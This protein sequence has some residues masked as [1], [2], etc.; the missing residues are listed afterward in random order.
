MSKLE[1]VN[2][3][4]SLRGFLRAAI[5]DRTFVTKEKMQK[6]QGVAKLI[7]EKILEEVL[8]SNFAIELLDEEEEIDE[9]LQE[10]IEAVDEAL[11]VLSKDAS[12]KPKK[13]TSAELDP[14]SQK[15]LEAMKAAV[16][17]SKKFKVK[18]RDQQ[19]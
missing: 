11:E 19:G 3:L 17:P 8:S 18:A 7:E 2:T 16:P 12:S 15:R 4:L 14:E 9:E 1:R 10:S 6:V 13:S 5:N